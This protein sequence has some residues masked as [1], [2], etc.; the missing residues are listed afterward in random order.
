MQKKMEFEDPEWRQN[1]CQVSSAHSKPYPTRFWYCTCIYIHF[2]A[3]KV[4]CLLLSADV[5]GMVTARSI[6]ETM[7]TVP[8][9]AWQ[10]DSR[11]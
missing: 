2:S 6:M 11:F 9:D 8:L 4:T 7:S 3:A 10:M 1:K 5:W